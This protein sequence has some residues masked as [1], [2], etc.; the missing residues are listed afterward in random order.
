MKEHPRCRPQRRHAANTINK[1]CQQRLST[2]RSTTFSTNTYDK[3]VNEE[4]LMQWQR[5]YSH[6]LSLILRHYK[7]R[8]RCYCKIRFQVRHKAQ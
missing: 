6:Q 8:Y 5:V 7:V 3:H 2:T 4:A 1:D